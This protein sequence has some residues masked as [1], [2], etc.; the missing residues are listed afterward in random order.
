MSL[1]S[2]ITLGLTTLG[3][4]CGIYYIHAAQERDREA[5][6]Q[7]IIRDLE[8]RNMKHTQNINRLAQQNTF[9][10]LLKEESSPNDPGSETITPN[11]K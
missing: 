7:G 11:K 5:L 2:K 3:T 9:E 10:R 6:H 8:R 1:A 4:A